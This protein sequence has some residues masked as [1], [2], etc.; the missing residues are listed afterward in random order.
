MTFHFM[1]FSISNR[2]L[3][4]VP[5]KFIGLFLI[6]YTIYLYNHR[7]DMVHFFINL[8][9]HNFFPCFCA[10][11]IVFEKSSREVLF[12]LTNRNLIKSFSNP[13]SKKIQFKI[14]V[15]PMLSSFLFCEF[16]AKIIRKSFYIIIFTQSIVFSS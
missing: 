12:S 14:C 15:K 11:L 9:N 2:F 5:E 6:V 16:T 10:V 7:H 3:S 4:L 13:V 8:F 1:V